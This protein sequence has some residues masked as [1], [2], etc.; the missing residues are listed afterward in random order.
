MVYSLLTICIDANAWEC[1][2]AK[3]KVEKLI[4]ADTDHQTKWLDDLLNSEYIRAI[5]RSDKPDQLRSDQRTW[6]R[7]IRNKCSTVMCLRRAYLKRI[8]LISR[9]SD[10]IEGVYF[11]NGSCITEPWEDEEGNFIGKDCNP[12]WINHLIIEKTSNNKYHIISEV[13]QF[14][15]G[16]FM[17]DA[18][19]FMNRNANIL[20]LSKWAD[21]EGP[22]AKCPFTITIKPDGFVI[23]TNGEQCGLCG[24]NGNFDGEVFPRKSNAK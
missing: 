11:T 8:P 15:T 21:E 22:D 7:T 24:R 23:S 9:S 6:L 19:A 16:N 18:D 10:D 17:C 1:K 2:E 3:T 5:D 12:P 20:S 14:A 13:A 4:C